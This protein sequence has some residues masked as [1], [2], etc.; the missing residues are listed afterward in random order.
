MDFKVYKEVI[1]CAGQ[2]NMSSK[3]FALIMKQKKAIK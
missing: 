1:K 2:L 3:E